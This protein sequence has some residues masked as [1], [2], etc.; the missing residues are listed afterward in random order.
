MSGDMMQ[1]ETQSKNTLKQPVQKVVHKVLRPVPLLLYQPLLKRIVR[2]ISGK[3][4][5]LFQRLGPHTDKSFLIDPVN[6]PFVLV[7]QPN[8]ERPR[9]RAYRSAEHLRCEAS[10]SGTFLTLLDMVDGR[11][12]GDAIFFTRDLK[13]EGDTEAIVSL[14]NALDNI[15]GSLADEIA[16]IYGGAGR[17]MLKAVRRLQQRKNENG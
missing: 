15:D 7:L 13:I 1:R 9:L 4:P 17:L 6:M 11:I 10:I 16:D 12:D 14:R 5:S 8:P 2:R 3:Y